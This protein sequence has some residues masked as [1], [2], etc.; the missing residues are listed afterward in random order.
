MIVEIILRT[1]SGPVP[2]RELSPQEAIRAFGVV[3]KAG[4]QK[5]VDL[6]RVGIKPPPQIYFSRALM[7]VP[8]N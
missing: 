3:P 8:A 1:P 7:R 4:H 2:I 6:K 5:E